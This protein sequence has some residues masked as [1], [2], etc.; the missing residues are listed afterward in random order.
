[1]ALSEE[2]YQALL[3]IAPEMNWRFHVAL[4][5]PHETGHRMGA[6]RDLRWRDV[7]LAQGRITWW[8]EHEKTGREHVTPMTPRARGAFEI[9]R[10]HAPGIGDAPVLPSPKDPSPPLGRYL[11]RDRWGNAERRAGLE[12][13]QGRGSPSLRR[14]FATDAIPE[15]LSLLAPFPRVSDP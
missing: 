7:D 8:V 3:A 13:K 6:I 2:A 12:R 14:K 4:V 11:V 5:L 9:A 1:V 15:H 10:R